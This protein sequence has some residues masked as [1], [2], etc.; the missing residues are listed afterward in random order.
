VGRRVRGC[1]IVGAVVEVVSSGVAP[2]WVG[3][4]PAF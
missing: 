2:Y 3:V 4:W 1:S